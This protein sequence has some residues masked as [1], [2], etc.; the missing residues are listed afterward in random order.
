MSKILLFGDLHIHHSHRFSLL[1]CNGYTTREKE[2]LQCADD[3]C[4]I[5]KE[6]NID[7]I[8]FLGDMIGPVGD[9][10]STQTLMVM[11]QFMQKLKSLDNVK[12]SLLVGNHD[13][14]GHINNRYSHK[15][16]PF[17]YDNKISVYSEPV[18]IGDYIFMPYC[19][20]NEYATSFLENIEDKKNKIVFSH[21]EIKG[22]NLGNGIE[23]DKGVELSLL[24]QF[25]YVFQGHY[26]NGINL[27]S[28]VIVAGS[29][30]RISFK[31]PG[32]SRKNIIIYD[33]DTN[34]IKRK[35]FSVADWL[36]F[37]DDN[38]QDILNISNDNYV[39]VEVTSDLFITPEIQNKLDHMKGKDVHIDVNRISLDTKFFD[40]SLQ[41]LNNKEDEF[42]V[43]SEFINKTDNDSKFKK[44]LLEK[45][46]ELLTEARNK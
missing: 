5:A 2:H 22:I 35:S 44:D 43:L 7:H 23:T 19:I 9:A 15:L 16:F 37:N 8:V 39:K 24:K 21:L 30:Q 34:V 13:I 11:I 29:T 36:C 25:K 41:E 40:N 6:E 45:G 46:L 12:L 32:I 20:S 27:A 26:H 10:L 33:T 31:D 4:R 28:N 14:S 17:C 3:I 1:D 18:S 42:E 38:I